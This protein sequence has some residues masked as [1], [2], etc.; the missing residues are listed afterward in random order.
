M[1]YILTGLWML[2]KGCRVMQ[3]TKLIGPFMLN[4]ALTLSN[5]QLEVL[6]WYKLQ[7]HD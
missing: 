1:K 4:E 5:E 2:K 7:R 3:G 6:G